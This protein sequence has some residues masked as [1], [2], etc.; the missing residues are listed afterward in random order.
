MKKK[1]FAVALVIGLALTAV[2]QEPWPVSNAQD[3]K[4]KKSVEESGKI[5]VIKEEG[6][7]GHSTI[8][9]AEDSVLVDSQKELPLTFKTLM[10]WKY[11]EENN[12]PTPKDIKNLNDRKVRLVGFMYPLQ[13]G[14]SILYFCL[15]RT[16]QTC[17][18]GP[19][20]QY[21]QYVFV[22]MKKPTRFHRL[23][24]VSCT[25][26]FKVEPTPEEGFIYRMEGNTCEA[27]AR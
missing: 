27:L 18:Y 13:E 17:C 22:E 6:P 23:D 1:S 12:P 24:P 5:R 20:P 25:G 7:S 10:T 3:A 26:I 19:R 15:L 14:D 4:N 21:N 9:I 2:L 11:D 16:T 8:G